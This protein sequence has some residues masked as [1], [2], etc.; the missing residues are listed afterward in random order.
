MT[1]SNFYINSNIY[2]VLQNKRQLPHQKLTFINYDD[3]VNAINDQL[4]K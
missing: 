2:K 4:K 3:Y 1:D